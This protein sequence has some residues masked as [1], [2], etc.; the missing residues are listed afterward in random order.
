MV[1]KNSTKISVLLTS[2]KYLMNNNTT[3]KITIYWKVSICRRI[4]ISGID[5]IWKAATLFIKLANININLAI[6]MVC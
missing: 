3:L 2:Y 4:T 1:K 5:N 6:Y